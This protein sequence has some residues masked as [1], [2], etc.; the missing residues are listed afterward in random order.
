GV[1]VVI[2]GGIYGGV[3]TPTEAA[4]VSVIYAL[5]V[6]AVIYREKSLKELMTAVMNSA[7][8]T[9][10]VMI[11]LSAAGVLAWFLTSQ[12]LAVGMTNAVLALSDNP[13]HIFLLINVAVIIVGM[14]LDAAS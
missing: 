12:G 10:Q 3:F 4:A 9:S 5:F 11:I 14:F 7:V 6:S 2:L 1:P 13:I 8:T